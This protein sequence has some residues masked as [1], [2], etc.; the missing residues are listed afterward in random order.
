MPDFFVL[1]LMFTFLYLF[2]L[3]VLLLYFLRRLVSLHMST[4]YEETHFF[5]GLSFPS[6][7]VP[8]LY[9]KILKVMTISS[10]FVSSLSVEN[11]SDR[12]SGKFRLHPGLSV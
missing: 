2:V 8:A 1:V 9:S 10:M 6:T 12:L 3:C 5:F 4:S 11:P 7:W